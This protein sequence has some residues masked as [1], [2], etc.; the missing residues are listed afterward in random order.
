ML[1][2]AMRDAQAEQAQIRSEM[3]RTR[4][5]IAPASLRKHTVKRSSAKTRLL[6][7]SAKPGTLRA[8]QSR[9]GPAG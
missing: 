3:A 6:T 7:A 8:N 5:Q 1:S 4:A 9:V 2:A